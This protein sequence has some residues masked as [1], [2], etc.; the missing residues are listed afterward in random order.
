[1]KRYMYN[2]ETDGAAGL[3]VLGDLRVGN[4]L[5]S[6]QE[7]YVTG[8]LMVNEVLWGDYSHG[9]V[10]I[11]ATATATAF[12]ERDMYFV[13][14]SGQA[15]FDHYSDQYGSQDNTVASENGS[16]YQGLS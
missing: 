13:N 9:D 1:M 7:V 15:N 8:K 14:I 11:L 5:V 2:E 16:R 12:V 3:I 4:I 10:R 6:G